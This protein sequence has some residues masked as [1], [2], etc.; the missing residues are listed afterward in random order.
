VLVARTSRLEIDASRAPLPI[1]GG[2]TS[3][4]GWRE[5]HLRAEAF[6]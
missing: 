2:T 5:L 4:F 6:A 1:T 3:E